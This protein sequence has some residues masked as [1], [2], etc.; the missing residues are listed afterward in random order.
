[1]VFMLPLRSK[2]CIVKKVWI[3][4]CASRLRAVMPK[5]KMH[6]LYKAII[7]DLLHDVPDKELREILL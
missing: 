1:M 3:N 2:V 7:K 6:I 5:E 4:G